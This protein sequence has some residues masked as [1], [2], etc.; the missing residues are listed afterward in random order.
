MTLRRKAGKRPR[1]NSTA[2][3]RALKSQVVKVLIVHLRKSWKT[4]NGVARGDSLRVL[5]YHGCSAR[6][7][8]KNFRQSP[9]TIRRQMELA[10]LPVAQRRAVNAG[11][12]AKK[13]LEAKA[14]SD[15]WRRAKERID[16]DLR[17][18]ALSDELTDIVL[19]F[20][21]GEAGLPPM[22]MV[23]D[24]LPMFLGCVATHLSEFEVYGKRGI[25]ATK[26]M[27]IDELFRQTR[28]PED[29]DVFWMDHQS[30][31]LANVILAKAPIRPIW[32]SALMKAQKRAAE[33]NV[34]DT[35]TPLEAYTDNE[36]RLVE[37]RFGLKNRPIYP[38]GA[39]RMLRQGRKPIS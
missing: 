32:E 37:V 2:H 7:L 10:S 16:D 22:R 25:R 3:K 1:R 14:V 13:I 28:P 26:S 18:G 33:L 23:P 9:T 4:M 27:G 20:C 6:G 19:D 31:W 30:E 15:R 11:A 34:E 39:S 38:G 24:D 8:A 29:E 12:S 17:T 35:R 21:R 36:A 5:V